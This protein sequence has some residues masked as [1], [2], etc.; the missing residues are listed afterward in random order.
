[1]KEIKPTNE[2]GNNQMCIRD[3]SEIA[4]FRPHISEQDAES[5]ARDGDVEDHGEGEDV[6]KRQTSWASI[7]ASLATTPSMA[8]S[9]PRAR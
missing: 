8:P 3:S 6:Y 5:L 9:M 7:P 2:T 4:S 1:M